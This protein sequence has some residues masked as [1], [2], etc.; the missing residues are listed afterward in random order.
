MQPINNER[1]SVLGFVSLMMVLL[2]IMV[3]MGLDTGHLSYIRS[4]GQPG[5]DAAALAAVQAL[6]TLSVT[7]VNNRAAQLNAGG[8]NPSGNNY[9]NSPNNLI[10]ASNVTLIKY[11]QATGTMIAAASIAE[12]NGVRVA[13]ETTNPYGGT[14]NTAMNAPLFLTPLLNLFGQNTS[15]THKV[16][17]SAVAILTAIPGFPIAVAGCSPPPASAN[18]TGGNGTEASPYT[19]CRLLQTDNSNNGNNGTL[20]FN[21]SGWTTLTIPSAN[22]PAIKALVRNN[23]TCGNMPPITVGSCIYLNNGQIKPVLSEF[24]DVYSGNGDGLSGTSQ[25]PNA[26]DWGVIPVIGSSVSN[27][28]QCQAVTSWAKFGI[29]DV[30]IKGNDKYL[31]G[32]LICDWTLDKVGATGCYTTQLVRDKLSGM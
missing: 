14:P 23:S 9:L 28:N 1:G 22:A 29:R 6:P 26:N 31:V 2:F 7:E 10:G 13:L 19:K 11:D 18:C 30:V 8:S 25:P 21:D 12:A 27:F 20:N 3:G 5:V 17:L 15:A 16:S 24:N 4:Q 32:D